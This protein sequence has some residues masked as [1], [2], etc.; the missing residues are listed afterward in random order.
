MFDFRVHDKQ[1]EQIM[2]CASDIRVLTEEFKKY[3][4]DQSMDSM[5]LNREHFIN[6]KKPLMSR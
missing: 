5:S 1:N 2:L 3:G 6:Q 4:P